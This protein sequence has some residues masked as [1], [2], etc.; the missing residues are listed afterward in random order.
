MGAVEASRTLSYFNGAGGATWSGV[1]NTEGTVTTVNGVTETYTLASDE[2]LTL[3][4][5]AVDGGL[6]LRGG[7]SAD[8]VLAVVSALT[9]GNRL[10]TRI[11][12]KK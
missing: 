6:T 7:V 12:M 3:V 11:Y 5:A 10:E 4:N 2:T 8:S 9:A 1:G